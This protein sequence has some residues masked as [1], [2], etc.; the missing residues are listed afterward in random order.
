MITWGGLIFTIMSIDKP[1]PADEFDVALRTSFR[2]KNG[3][4]L[5]KSH[6]AHLIISPMNAMNDQLQAIYL[7]LRVMTIA[8]L[9]AQ[10]S[11]PLAFYW[12]K[13]QVL[14][15]CEQF[16]QAVREAGDAMQKFN[17]NIPNALYE[18]PTTYLA[19][20]RILSSD[21]KSRFGAITKGLDVLTGFEIQIDPFDGKPSEVARHLYGM[22][23]YILAN[24]PVFSEGNTIGMEQDKLFSMR[25]IPSNE[26]LPPR[27]AMKLESIN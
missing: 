16:S 21:N 6:K 27:W 20:L 15:D 13:S 24:G 25:M 11:E 1:I 9:L 2:L 10:Q 23:G 5:I 3:E 22:V 18:L 8:D 7:A 17:S 14:A 12:N 19:G 26:E 4:N